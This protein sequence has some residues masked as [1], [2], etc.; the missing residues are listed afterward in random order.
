[1][2]ALFKALCWAL[3]RKKDYSY[4]TEGRGETQVF[5]EAMTHLSAIIALEDEN[6]CPHLKIFFISLFQNY[7]PIFLSLNTI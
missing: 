5:G 3:L 7:I 1:M 6:Y 4:L 2:S